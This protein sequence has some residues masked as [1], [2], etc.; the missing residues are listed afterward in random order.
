LFVTRAESFLWHL[1][2]NEARTQPALQNIIAEPYHTV[3][4]TF[5]CRMRVSAVTNG[6]PSTIAVAA[7]K[8]SAGS[9][10][11]SSGKRTDKAAISA[12]T[13]LR[14][15]LATSS[16]TND[17][18]LTATAIRPLCASH[19]SSHN[20]IV[21]TAIP[22]LCRPCPCLASSKV[23]SGTGADI[24]MESLHSLTWFVC[25][26]AAWLSLPRP[27]TQNAS[28]AIGPVHAHRDM[29]H[30][31]SCPGPCLGREGRRPGRERLARC[32]SSSGRGCVAD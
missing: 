29:F 28:R 30:L 5:D 12:V 4:T 7:I 1:Q 31:L 32:G 18:T 16:R 14:I 23:Y 25:G 20:V 2:G 9:L 22:A 17:S 15:T 21:A 26:L 19:A 3:S 27:V 10:G 8:R 24:V 6:M 11:N 13:G